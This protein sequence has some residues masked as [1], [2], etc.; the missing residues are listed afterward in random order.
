MHS[1]LLNHYF[2]GG[3][4]IRGGPSEVIFN[5]ILTLEKYNG[6][7]LV[8]APVQKILMNDK[9][10]AHGELFFYFISVVLPF[11]LQVFCHQNQH[12]Y[13]MQHCLTIMLKTPTISVG[14][15]VN[16]LFK[17]YNVSKKMVAKY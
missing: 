13:C 5:M 14:D 11:A 9:G 10:H 12:L 8:K 15:R 17:L 3:Y 4:Y 16:F 2:N 1:A 6:R 7:I